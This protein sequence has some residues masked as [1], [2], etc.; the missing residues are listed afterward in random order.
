MISV[1]AD[2]GLVFDSR[3]E[4]YDLMALKT[5]SGLNKAGTLVLTMPP[6]HPAYNYFTRNKTVVTLYENGVLKWRG[7]ALYPAED[8]FNCRTITC[9]GERG[10]FRDAVMRPYLYTDTPA[11]I[12]ADAL[13]KYNAE[14][15][16]FKR[17]TLGRVTVTDPN[18]YVR[19]E[20]ESADTFATFFDKLVDRCGGYITFSDD[21]NGGRCVNWLA[22]IGT[23]SGQAIEFGENLLDFSSTGENED[24][25]TAIVPYGA[26][27]EDGTRLSIASV[28][29]GKDWIQDDVAVLRFGRIAITET[30]DDVTLP[31]NLL[32]KAQQRLDERKVVITSLEL[33]A[34]DLSKMDI[35]IDSYEDGDMVPVISKPHGINEEF[36]LTDRSTDWLAPQDSTV[37][38]GKTVTSLTGSDVKAQKK[39]QA[40]IDIINTAQVNQQMQ[41]TETAHALVSRIEQTSESILLEVSETYS[42]KSETQEEMQELSSKIDMTSSSIL[43]EVSEN[44]SLKTETAAEVLELS[45]KIDM[46][47]ESIL[48]Q[49]SESYTKK[50]E[51]EEEVRELESKIQQTSG[52]ILL[53]ISGTYSTKSELVDEI[54]TLNTKIDMLDGNINLEVSE[55]YATKGQL[56]TVQ[57]ELESKINISKESILLSVSENYTKKTETDEEVRELESKIDLQQ[58]S[59]LLEVSGTYSTKTELQEQVKTL[60][61]KI[62]LVDGNINMEVTSTFATKT[63]LAEQYTELNSKITLSESSILSQV[64]QS[65]TTQGE[66]YDEVTTLESKIQQLADSITLEVIGGLGSTASI[67]MTVGD[68]TMTE[69]LDME[70]VRQA[71]AEDTSSISLS[72]GRITFN[73]GTIVI[74]SGNFTLDSSGNI[75]ASNGTFDG[76]FTTVDGKYKT[77]INNGSVFLYYEDELAATIS[78]RYNPGADAPGVTLR[79]EDGGQYLMFCSPNSDYYSGFQIDYYLNA[80]WSPEIEEKHVFQSSARFM[81]KTVLYKAYCQNLYIY[82]GVPVKSCDF[83][84]N[85][86]DEVLCYD[87]DASLC[88]I[89][90]RYC[91]NT[92]VRGDNAAIMAESQAAVI[93]DEIVFSTGST[94]S[95]N[96]GLTVTS[97]RNKKHSI[98]VLPEAY[99]RF[100]DGLDPVRFKYNDGTS[101]RYHVGYIAQDVETALIGAG[102]DSADFAGYVNLRGSGELG[103]R[104]D[105]FIAILHKKIKRL[106]AQVAALQLAQ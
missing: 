16:D 60:N 45:S 101:G 67:K 22:E 53:E 12:F 1:Y 55:V 89:S 31:E 68:L 64:S 36:Q 10:F 5:T 70:S 56:G 93:G 96:V 3:L 92:W 52:S 48:L 77:E 104:Y 19:L 87:H 100:I 41:I 62:D 65:Y 57:S 6:G 75:T 106:E 80:G 28:N 78:T 69:S 30:W 81:D 17:F 24:F 84:G 73:S 42:T 79:V 34:L 76:D 51:T 103:L 46:T 85:I 97:D 32:R 59:I 18:N 83:D 9:E 90:N 38:L 95:S 98:E 58:T 99:E 23:K 14:V 105:E 13:E 86:G 39:T 4:V 11:A 27:N 47:Q 15:D 44:Y 72:A 88:E 94:L 61:A 7:R 37:V 102:L 43:L 49:V 2:R 91:S 29:G 26:Q 71:F 35:S 20:C 40:E 8:V 63:E 50:T 66:L 54:T 33:S 74:N 82:S 21:G 25:A